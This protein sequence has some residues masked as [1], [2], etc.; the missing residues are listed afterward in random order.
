MCQVHLALSSQ[1]HAEYISVLF[2][3]CR[4]GQMKVI[5]LPI[6]TGNITRTYGFRKFEMRCQKIHGASTKHE[7]LMSL[8]QHKMEKVFCSCRWFVCFV[9]AVLCS[10]QGS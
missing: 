4:K 3:E 7:K 1:E 5:C 6:F 8:S 10:L 2:E 9:L